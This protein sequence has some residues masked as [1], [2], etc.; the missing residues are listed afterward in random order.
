M[1]NSST[2]ALTLR[3]TATDTIG[4]TASDDVNVNV[5]N[6]D[7]VPVISIVTPEADSTVAGTINIE[8]DAYD[9]HGV[10]QVDFFIDDVLQYVKQVEK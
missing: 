1:S 3:A 2:S 4:Q 8:A 9:D 6:T 10:E 5:D 7:E